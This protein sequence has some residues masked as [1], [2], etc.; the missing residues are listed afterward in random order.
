MSTKTGANIQNRAV[1]LIEQGIEQA[2]SSKLFVT[3]TRPKGTDRDELACEGVSRKLREGAAVVEVYDSMTP[4]AFIGAICRA[5]GEAEKGS[6]DQA[7]NR[8]IASLIEKPKTL[9]IE[10]ANYLGVKS[11][12]QLVHINNRARVGMVLM[13]TE[14]LYFAIERPMLQRVRSRLRQ[15]L[16]LDDYVDK[17]PEPEGS[18]AKK[19]LKGKFG[20]A[21][22]GQ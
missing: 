6:L 5:L 12:N 16:S 19:V 21:G 14:E 20:K 8:A 1:R 2:G 17:E 18:K 22:S 11:M 10:E 7:L 4:R 15:S 9:V 13:G 3:I